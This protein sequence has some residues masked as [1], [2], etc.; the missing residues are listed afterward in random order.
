MF[1]SYEVP[2]PKVLSYDDACHLKKFLE[3]RANMGAAFASWVLDNMDL[4]VDKCAAAA[5]PLVP[6]ALLSHVPHTLR[7]PRWQV[8]LAKSQEQHLL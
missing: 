7:C 3:N 1:H 2:P 5:T 8:P 4:A 6:P